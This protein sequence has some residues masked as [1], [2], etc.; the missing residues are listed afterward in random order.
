M[1]LITT[2]ILITNVRHSQNDL[3]IRGLSHILGVIEAIVKN[4]NLPYSR[5]SVLLS[6]G[7]LIKAVLYKKNRLYVSD[8]ETLVRFYV[9]LN[10][11]KEH[12]LFEDLLWFWERF[13]VADYSIFKELLS[14][15]ELLTSSVSTKSALIKLTL[16]TILRLEIIPSYYLY[17]RKC[18]QFI[19]KG[20]ISYTIS[21]CDDCL[22]SKNVPSD[23]PLLRID[24]YTLDGILKFLKDLKKEWSHFV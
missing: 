22:N 13:W 11:Y 7:T 3:Y 8:F 19:K 12:L 14:Q 5:R 21:Y 20:R 24:L 9:N 6:K 10:T 17:C 23:F 15:L 18:R 2:D 4:A 16:W 1:R